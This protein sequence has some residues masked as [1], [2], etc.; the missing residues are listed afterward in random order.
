MFNIMRLFQRTLRNRIDLLNKLFAID[1]SSSIL[2]NY[3]SKSSSNTVS[4]VLSNGYSF[5]GYVYD[6]NNHLIA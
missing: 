4:A 5:R 6:V 3:S 2:K 1:G